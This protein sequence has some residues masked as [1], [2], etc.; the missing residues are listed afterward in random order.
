MTTS[1]NHA[2]ILSLSLSTA[3]GV[4]LSVAACNPDE[5]ALVSPR[6][7]IWIYTETNLVSNSCGEDATLD[8]IASFLID[9]D[10]GEYFDI[11]RGEEDI[12]CEIDGY[13]FSC[14][15]ISLG[16]VDLA[17]LVEVAIEFKVHYRG[18]FDSDSEGRGTEIVTVT[19]TGADCEETEGLPCTHVADFEFIFAAG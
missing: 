9:Y 7:G 8:P 6:N 17:P 3:L 18:I 10:G 4:L 2:L 5:P 1:L 15:T 19:C 12:S 16:I 13:A 11:E 14:D